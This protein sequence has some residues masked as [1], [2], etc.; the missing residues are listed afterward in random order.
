[1]AGLR[2]TVTVVNLLVKGVNIL[3]VAHFGCHIILS[4]HMLGS[5]D[6]FFTLL[7]GM[8]N[9]TGGWDWVIRQLTNL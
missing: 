9:G 8:V 1:M 7:G 5:E 2:F 6:L 4:I 3:V